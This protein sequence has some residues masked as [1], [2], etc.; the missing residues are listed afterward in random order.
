MKLTLVRE[1]IT[2]IALT[3]ALPS[4]TINNGDDDDSAEDDLVETVGEDAGPTATE[5]PTGEPTGTTDAAVDTGE[6][7]ESDA[8]ADTSEVADAA[9]EDGAEDA[10][11]IAADAGTDASTDARDGGEDGGN[12]SD[13]ALNLPPDPGAGGDETVEGVD[14]NANGIRDDVERNLGALYCPNHRLIEL[15]SRLAKLDQTM[16]LG[17]TD[18][19]VVSGAFD[20]KKLVLSCLS[21]E[22]DGDIAELLQIVGDVSA[23][24]FNTGARL[25]A[26]RQIES[27]LGGQ[28]ITLPTDAQVT[29]YCGGE[30]AAVVSLQAETA[31][32]CSVTGATTITLSNDAFN[33]HDKSLVHLMALRNAAIAAGGE[34]AETYGYRLLYADS[35]RL[36][37]SATT[38]EALLADAEVL[39]DFA[40]ARPRTDLD[41]INRWLSGAGSVPQF[42][43]APIAGL[44]A[45]TGSDAVVEEADLNGHVAG[46]T[47]DA[48]V[49]NRIVA[50]GH[51]LGTNYLNQAYTQLMDSLP[52]FAGS[53]QLIAFGTP[54]SELAGSAEPSYLNLEGDW[55][56]SSAYQALNPN[57]LAAN[58]QNQSSAQDASNHEL[59]FSYLAGDSS[60]E[61]ARG[62]IADALEGVPY[63]EQTGANGIITVTLTWGEEPD[64]D[65]HAFEPDG[66]HVYYS[67]QVGPVGELDVDDTN[68]F[69]P[70]HYTVSCAKLVAGTY[71]LGVNYFSGQSPEKAVV[72][73]VAGTQSRTINV[74]LETARSSAGDDTPIPVAEI[75]VT[76]GGDEGEFIFG[77]RST[78]DEGDD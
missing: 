33:R 22:F 52:D 7:A 34:D 38:D 29:A 35:E 21:A 10:G 43:Q 65:L 56:V 58:V 78:I 76:A 36:W 19:N 66:S 67:A 26:S 69:G 59:Y 49:G 27:Q 12:C 18:P 14:S 51:G 42:M 55:A 73:I 1:S 37:A 17:V 39:G 70:E 40:Q 74:A 61:V 4:C 53:M 30:T 5:E 50:F 63:P 13:E 9:T 75:V 25:G 32:L 64:V 46:L 47:A 44:S 20:E 62:L 45:L 28:V 54:T 57:P 16:L 60:G 23:L 68:Q 15:T 71:Q 8:G 24:V 31:Q 77:I 3:L 6:A 41:S 48:T 2:V 11:P 72:N